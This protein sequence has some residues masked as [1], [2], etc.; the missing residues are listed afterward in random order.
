MTTKNELEADVEELHEDVLEA[1]PAESRLKLMMEAHEEG[2]EDRMERL[3]ETCPTKTYEMRAHEYRQSFDNSFIIAV[4]GVYEL[5]L[6][7][8]R[9]LH[10]E[11]VLQFYLSIC[12]V[13]GIDPAG[14]GRQMR[15]LIEDFCYE[16]HIDLHNFYEGFRR[17]AEE[18]ID[19]PLE[20]LL[21]W[22]PEGAY[23]VD[24]VRAAL[25]DR[26]WIL[27][28]GVL[29]KSLLHE[30]TDEVHQELTAAWEEA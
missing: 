17:F 10:T 11:S 13:K 3:L 26:E 27:E 24:E 21:T 7:H 25:E 4:S 1:I 5:K 6:L 15:D 12:E 30:P 18:D 2:Q 19:V 28:E 20:T 23:V 8:Q 16:A 29:D 22:H 9:L 14:E